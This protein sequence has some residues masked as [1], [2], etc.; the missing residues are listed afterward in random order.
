IWKIR[1]IPDEPGEWTYVYDWSDGTKGGKGKIFCTAKGAGKGILRPYEQNP[2]WFAYNGTE[3]VWLKSYYET[4]HGSIGQDFDWIVENVYSKFVSAGYNHLQVNWLLSLCCFGQ[5][6][7]DGPEP[8]TLDLSLYQEGDIYGS[9]NLDVWRRMEQHL[10]W[11]NDQNIGVHMFLGVDGSRNDGPDWSNLSFQERDWF[12]RYMVSRLAPYANLAGWNFVWEV[13]GDREDK[14]LGFVRLIQKYDI[15]NHLRTYEDEAPRDN[16]YARPE[17]TFA[18]V[19]N[20][21]IVANE[22]D[23]ERHLLKEPWTHHMA[24]L[25]GYKGKPVFMSEGNALW[26]RYWQQR[27]KATQDDLRRSAWACATAGASFTWNGHAHEYELY[28]DGPEGLPFNKANPYTESE[29]YISILADILET[30]VVFYK[31]AP[32]DKLLADSP[33][34]RVYLLAE[35]GAQYLVFSTEGQVFSLNM[36]K[37]TYSYIVWIDAKT[38][39]KV[40]REEMTVKDEQDTVPFDPPNRL[41]DWVLIVK[42]SQDRE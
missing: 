33:G 32:H 21:R 10:G 31:M 1:F 3:P 16:E 2:H 29:K 27:T 28:V 41:S 35:P 12:V 7:K 5:Y 40:F 14:E 13:P 4:G 30:E 20:H 17:Y 19:E 6:Y 15:F 37:G 11:L 24:C 36:E 9:M 22:R 39:R 38:G 25:V 34:L 8:E 18:A 42:N 26:R 23:L